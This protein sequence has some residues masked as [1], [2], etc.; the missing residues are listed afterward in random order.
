MIKLVEIMDIENHPDPKVEKLIVTKVRV[1]GEPDSELLQVVTNDKQLKV[2]N[3][4]M[5]AMVGHVF[6]KEGEK[7]FEITERKV[8][9]IDS[10][11]MFCGEEELGLPNLRTG[12]VVFPSS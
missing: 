1:A 3:F 8:M 12:V 9:G 10:F 4:V 5:L 2:G 6:K 11:G 7:D